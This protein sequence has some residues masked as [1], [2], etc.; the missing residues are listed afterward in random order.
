M[1]Y[2]EDDYSDKESYE[3][4]YSDY[5]SYEDDYEYYEDEREFYP[6]DF[7]C[8]LTKEQLLQKEQYKYIDNMIQRYENDPHPF[9][10]NFQLNEYWGRDFKSECIKKYGLSCETV[11]TAFDEIIV[12][13]RETCAESSR[14]RYIKFINEIVFKLESSF[15]YLS[16]VYS[17]F[18]GHH[19]SFGVGVFNTYGIRRFREI[20]RSSYNDIFLSCM[21]MALIQRMKWRHGDYRE[22]EGRFASVYT[23]VSGDK[24]Q[25]LEQV[26]PEFVEFLTDILPNASGNTDY[27]KWFRE[28]IG[29]YSLDFNIEGFVSELLNHVVKDGD[30]LHCNSVLPLGAKRVVTY[31]EKLFELVSTIPTPVPVR[32]IATH[33]ERF[34]AYYYGVSVETI[35]GWQKKDVVSVSA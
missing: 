23:R 20:P 16:P 26:V 1:S 31:G 9:P 4:D 18:M 8:F 27:C 24:S 3:D 6:V 25:F 35:R 7:E 11:N 28:N 2:S 22:I 12:V 29:Y 13:V 10:S 30:D 34:Y 21:K 32:K 17:E 5:G 19:H 14:K 15:D 33:S